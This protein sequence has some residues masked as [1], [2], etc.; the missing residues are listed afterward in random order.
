MCI[1]HVI[2]R[3]LVGLIKILIKMDQNFLVEYDLVE[4]IRIFN[5]YDQNLWFVYFQSSR[6]EEMLK[7]RPK[8]DVSKRN[9][10]FL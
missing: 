1:C 9:S 3:V 5:W 7:S 10:S 4:I 2:E 6:K 8:K